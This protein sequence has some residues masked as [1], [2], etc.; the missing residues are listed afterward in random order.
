MSAH[1]KRGKFAEVIPPPVPVKEAIKARKRKIAEETGQLDETDPTSTSAGTSSF[2]QPAPIPLPSLNPTSTPTPA[3]NAESESTQA[4][5]SAS[6][7]LSLKALLNA[8]DEA[9]QAEETQEP[10]SNGVP[11]S[12]ISEDVQMAS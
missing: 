10:S 12:Q 4:N 7:S 9:S 6:R 2:P 3:T 8:A 1:V 5:G 11:T